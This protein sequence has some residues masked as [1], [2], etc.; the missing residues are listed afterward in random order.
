MTALP[1]P[2]ARIMF[3]GQPGRVLRLPGALSYRWMRRIN[4][5]RIRPQDRK[6]WIFI[7]VLLRKPQGLIPLRQSHHNPKLHVAVAA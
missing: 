4:L 7:R 1:I 5:T 6:T 2:A 3:P